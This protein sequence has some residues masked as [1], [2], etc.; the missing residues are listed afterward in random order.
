MKEY[1]HDKQKKKGAKLHTVRRRYFKTGGITVEQV[2]IIHDLDG[3][4]VRFEDIEGTGVE[5][6]HVVDSGL[7]NFTDD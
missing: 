1:G 6:E 2:A 7:F 5:F 3:G 4:E